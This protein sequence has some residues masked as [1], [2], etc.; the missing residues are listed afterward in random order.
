MVSMQGFIQVEG[1]ERGEWF[2]AGFHTGGREGGGEWFLCEVC[3]PEGDL[4]VNST[5]LGIWADL[6]LFLVMSGGLLWYLVTSCGV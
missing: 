2:Y 5:L 1:K 6:N 4:G 3:C